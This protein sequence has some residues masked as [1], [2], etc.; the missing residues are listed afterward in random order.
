MKGVATDPHDPSSVSNVAYVNAVGQNI[1]D[2]VGDGLTRMDDKVNKIGAGA[3]AMASLVPGS[4][5]DDSKWNISAAVGNYR[6]ATA[7]AVGAFYKPVGNV[8]VAIKGSFGNGENM[9]GGGVGV[10]LNKGSMPGVTKAVMVRTINAQAREIQSMKSA[11]EQD[12]AMIANQST[13]IEEQMKRIERLETALRQMM[14]DR[15]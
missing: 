9:I 5:E 12:R 7:G 6:D 8:T 14:D 10:A 2:R 11:R 13:R 1:L 15:K 3:A 4:F